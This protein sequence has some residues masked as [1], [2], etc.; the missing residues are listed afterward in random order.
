M[1]FF[2]INIMNLQKYKWKLRLLYIT[3]PSYKNPDYIMTKKIYEK[4]IKNFHKRHIRLITKR[5]KN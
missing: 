5:K 2:L 1:E 3:T 4:N